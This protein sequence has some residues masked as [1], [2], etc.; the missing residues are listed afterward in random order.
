MMLTIIILDL[1]I[2]G[3]E[4]DNELRKPTKNFIEN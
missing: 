4:A 3:T 1:L 2:R